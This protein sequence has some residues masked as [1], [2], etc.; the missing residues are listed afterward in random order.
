LSI[1]YRVIRIIALSLHLII[2]SSF[3]RRSLVRRRGFIASSPPV[4]A[5]STN[6]NNQIPNSLPTGRQANKSQIPMFNI[7]KT[8][9]FKQP[10]SGYQTFKPS[11]P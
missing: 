3:T 8:Q 4:R 10:R 2:A 6:P 9:T 11:Q 7:Q 1:E 5:P